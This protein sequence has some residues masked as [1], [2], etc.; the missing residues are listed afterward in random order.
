MS[1][2]LEGLCPLPLPPGSPGSAR[3]LPLPPLSLRDFGCRQ[4]AFRVLYLTPYSTG[5]NGRVKLTATEPFSGSWSA[6]LARFQILLPSE[7][8][9]AFSIRGCLPRSV[10]PSSP[11]SLHLTLSGL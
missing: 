7:R 3:L 10:F 8:V 5:I 1:T 4:Q 6:G 2:Y 11:P 9:L